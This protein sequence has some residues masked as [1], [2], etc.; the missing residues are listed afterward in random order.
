MS[1]FKD[2][3]EKEEK[4]NYNVRSKDV[5]TSIVRKNIKRP[6]RRKKSI[7]YTTEKEF[8]FLK[9]FII[10]KYF[11]KRTEFKDLQDR[12]IEFFLF[13][14][15]E[16][17]FTRQDFKDYEEMLAWDSGRLNKY[18]EKGYIVKYEVT[19]KHKGRG[20]KTKLYTLSKKTKNV[21]R[22]FYDKLMLRY[23]F[24]EYNTHNPLM[25]EKSRSYV[26][27]RFA[28][29]IKQMNSGK[30]NERKTEEDYDDLNNLSFS[31]FVKEHNKTNYETINTPK[32]IKKELN[33]KED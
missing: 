11:Y 29:K 14:Y 31:E 4:G 7:T 17:P 27:K 6:K 15:S 21:I 30:F 13:L 25:R 20:T 28:K 12:E 19:K 10:V 1:E 26:D 32:E 3:L 2:F 22:A 33:K 8:D 9:Y 16:P 5:V 23:K 18:L 24:S